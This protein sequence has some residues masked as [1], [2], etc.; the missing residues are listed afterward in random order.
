MNSRLNIVANIREG[1]DMRKTEYR[2]KITPREFFFFY[3]LILVN[4]FG[5]EVKGGGIQSTEFNFRLA[6][7]F[8]LTVIDFPVDFICLPRRLLSFNTRLATGNCRKLPNFQLLI[9]PCFAVT[10]LRGTFLHQ[11]H[12]MV[13]PVICKGNNITA[14]I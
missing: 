13:V 9:Q 5:K 12:C 4:S 11:G 1:N 7:F 6:T 2:Q 14:S 3:G 10:M 8:G